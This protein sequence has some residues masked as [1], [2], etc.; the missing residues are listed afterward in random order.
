MK[1]W[2]QISLTICALMFSINTF[3]G[4]KVIAHRGGS[5][6]APENTAAAF[7]N[8]VALK[9]DYFELDI[10]TSIDDSLMIMHDATIDRTTN[11]SGTLSSKS[12]QLLR[13][14]DAGSW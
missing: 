4:V 13:F 9:A 5:Y 14:L 2:I 3:G 12:Y 10:Q 7:R 8:A 11:S 1:K 6:L